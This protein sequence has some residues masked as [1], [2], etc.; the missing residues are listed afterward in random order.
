MQ[1]K[2]PVVRWTILAASYDLLRQSELFQ[3]S[4]RTAAATQ[5]HR[6]REGYQNLSPHWDEG[7][8]NIVDSCSKQKD[9]SVDYQSCRLRL[10]G[11]KNHWRSIM[12]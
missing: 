9:V 10:N 6:T 5:A 3:T 11:F 8:A 12:D 7:F 2:N 4:A 1:P